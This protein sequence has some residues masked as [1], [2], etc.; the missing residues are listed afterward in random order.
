M[1]H[2]SKIAFITGGNKVIGF[3]TARQQTSALRKDRHSL[4]RER[5]RI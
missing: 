1:S 4:T 3:E 5:I 2:H